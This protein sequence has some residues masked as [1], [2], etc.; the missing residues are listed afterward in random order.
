MAYTLSSV[1]E[2]VALATNRRNKDNTDRIQVRLK[3]MA[4]TGVLETVQE[5]TEGGRPYRV[6]SPDEACIAVLFAQLAD[7]NFALDTLKNLRNGLLLPATGVLEMPAK[8]GAKIEVP[9][10]GADPHDP[11][12]TLQPK[13]HLSR[14]L[15]EVWAGK[16]WHYVISLGVSRDGGPTYRSG[17][18]PAGERKDSAA[19][20]EL[21]ERHGIVE[22]APVIIDLSTALR[23]TMKVLREV[24]QTADWE[25]CD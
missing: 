11:K 16:A 18:W 3:K 9:Y 17:L 4:D 19:M 12:A 20:R 22:F 13:R 14:V 10:W 23:P 7:F 24:N 6:L 5:Q 1:A 25:V 8:G 2:A 15:P 21:L